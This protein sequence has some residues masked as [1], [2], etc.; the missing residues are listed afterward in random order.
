MSTVLITGG[1]GFFGEILTR[2][3]LDAGFCCV[4]LDLHATELRHDRLTAVQG[5]VRDRRLLDR[6]CSERK[7]EAVFHL[8]ALLAHDVRDKQLLWSC[9]VDGTRAIAEA[10]QRHRIRRVV[11]T[12][13]NCLWGRPFDRPV[14]E[15][16]PPQ[17][18]EI[19]GESKWQ[20]EQIL[21]EYA[22]DFLAIVIRCPTIIDCGRL[23]LLA[24]LFEFIDEG[25]R[26]WVV[27]GGK[28]RYQFIYAQDL[29][30]ACLE[31][32]E[33]DRSDVF[34][35]GSDDVKSFAEIYAYVA[36][37]AGTGARV[38]T[39]PKRP[40]IFA[41]KVAH[42]LGLSPLGPYQ[43]KMITESFVFDTTKIKSRLSWRPT[44]TNEEM[45]LKAF[46]YYRDHLAEIRARTDVSAHKQA[47]KMGLIR[48]LK[49]IS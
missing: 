43:Y 2:R 40:T 32:L 44:L 26:V 31:S 27:G 22:N 33:C 6:L 25:R 23:G 48:L 41:M 24:I 14:L 19:Y 9:N 47:A 1:A 42:A 49:L 35:I 13:S 38:A 39:L 11:F 10:A 46:E 30:T 15:S 7:F 45:L 20:A 3:L 8:A 17:P 21:G 29:A 12:S 37:K 5:D 16:D 36:E 34:N 4:A 18:I 28:N